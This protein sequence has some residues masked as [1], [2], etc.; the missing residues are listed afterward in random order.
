MV[1]LVLLLALVPLA[2]CGQDMNMM[3]QMMQQMMM[4]QQQNKG[5]NSDYGMTQMNQNQNNMQ[6]QNG[7]MGGMSQEDYEAYL[8]WC[9]EKKMVS[10]A[11]EQQ[12]NLMK[13]YEE[14]E[15]ERKAENERNRLQH[16]AEE[17]HEMMMSQYKN[18]QRRL[19]EQE[20]FDSLEY[21]LMEM[22]HKYT[23]M[24]TAEFLKF[25]KCSD[26]TADLEKFFMHDGVTVTSQEFNLDDLE[27]IDSTD[28]VA[29][30]QALAN[31]PQVDQIKAFFGGL[32]GSMCE[33][34]R[35]YVE[36]L[37]AWEKEYNFI[38]RLM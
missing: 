31:R 22:K 4:Q 7:M 30:A 10:T 28:A 9:E 1:P 25:C 13:M 6:H 29:V 27:G 11:Q 18:Y 34:A 16:E 19:E 32:A 23:F 17:R 8:K 5:W 15:Q 20:E 33:G 38:E 2:Y 36:Q 37:M 24:L 26:F 3:Q 14:R 21:A 12:K 35:G